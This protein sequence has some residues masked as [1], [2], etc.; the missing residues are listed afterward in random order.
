M[1][2]QTVELPNIR[3]LFVPDPGYLMVDA[4]LAGA[5]ARVVAWDANDEDLKAA[6]RAGINIHVKNARDIFPD[7]VRGMSDEAIEATDRPGGI[8]HDNKRAVHATNYGASAKTLAIT[9][10]WT[11]REAEAFQRTWFSLHPAIGDWHDRVSTDLSSSR[12]VSNRFG[13]RRVYF[14]RVD[15]LLPEAL[16]WIP[17]STVAL[18][19]IKAALM[20]YETL[21]WVQLL[22]QEHDSLVFQIPM[23][24][25]PE[26][27][28]I[29]EAMKVVVP[30][31]DPLIIPWGVK[32]S[33]LS[34]G[35]CK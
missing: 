17:Q 14:D 6:F 3:K 35:D 5:D 7:K 25:K 27:P 1:V 11:I 28:S 31:D 15:G 34:W 23:A 9:L 12:T 19:T 20:I 4:D 8:Y 16:A 10:G 18:V 33:T 13:Y 26:L 29:L 2:A 22:L 30:Y 32:T 24:R 21:R